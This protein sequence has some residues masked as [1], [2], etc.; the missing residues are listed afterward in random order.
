MKDQQTAFYLLSI[1]LAAHKQG[2]SGLYFL[3]SW[4]HVGRFL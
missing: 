1:L 4:N 3:S 2:I